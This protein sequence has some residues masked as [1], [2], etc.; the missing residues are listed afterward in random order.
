VSSKAKY[1]GFNTFCNRVKDGIEFRVIQHGV[2]YLIFV[3][4]HFR[5]E[6]N[7]IVRYAA[8]RQS[9]KMAVGHAERDGAI[10]ERKINVVKMSRL[11]FQDDFPR[12]PPS[13]KGEARYGED[14]GVSVGGGGRGDR[15]WTPQVTGIQFGKRR[16]DHVTRAHEEKAF[17]G[18]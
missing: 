14:L 6:E 7:A 5:Q 4:E 11:E 12:D 16:T 15:Q 8:I 2:S 9:L 3:A 17:S 1:E 18:L 13:E 10:V